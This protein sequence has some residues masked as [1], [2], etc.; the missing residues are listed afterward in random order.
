MQLAGVQAYG[1]D[2]VALAIRDEQV[3]HLELVEELDLLLDAVLV[4]RLQDH[5]PGA[6]GG[7]TGALDGLFGLVVG[8]AAKPAL[9]DLAVGRAVKGQA[10]VLKVDDG[11]DGVAAHD[12]DRVLIAQE[13]AAL[14]RVIGVPLPL[15]GF[16]VAERG[17]NAALGGAG[18]RARRIELGDHG[19]LY[20][21]AGVQGGHEAGSAGAHD[22]RVKLMMVNHGVC[23]VSR[24]P[25]GAPPLVY[26]LSGDAPINS[27][28]APR[29]VR[30]MMRT[31]A[32]SS[33]PR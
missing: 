15:V 8:V 9:A 19:G 26:R 30:T 18:V 21:L 1:H 23:L 14:D 11:V 12:V 4:K 28:I 6:V 17:R 5:V 16:H 27:A 32:T 22:E 24:R 33:A 3:D 25:S 13:V 10:H 29:R 20:A 2:A 31:P 7:V